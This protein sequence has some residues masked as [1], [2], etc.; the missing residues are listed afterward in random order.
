MKSLT[1]TIITAIAFMLIISCNSMEEPSTNEISEQVDTLAV[2]STIDSMRTAFEEAVD[3]RDMQSLSALVAE[4]AIFVHPGGED[5]KRM[6]AQTESFPAYEN[7]KITPIEIQVINNEWAF[8]FGTS[9]AAYTPDGSDTAREVSDTYL[10][11]FRNTPDGWRIYKEVA[12]SSPPPEN[13][14]E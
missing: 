1:L 5:W 6:E 13:T 10:V 2:I 9:V 11:V 4:D 7:I 3:S 14:T 12:S 8:E